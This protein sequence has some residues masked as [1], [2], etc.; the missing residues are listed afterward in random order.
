MAAGPFGSLKSGCP[1]APDRSIF[2]YLLYF[3]GAMQIAEGSASSLPA[4]EDCP[5]RKES[6][7]MALPNVAPVPFSNSCLR[8]QIT[9]LKSFAAMLVLAVCALAAQAQAPSA[10]RVAQSFDPTP[11]VVLKGHHP[12]WAM[13]TNDRG[14]LNGNKVIDNLTMVLARS[15]EQQKAFEQLLSDQQT[16]G[17]PEYHHWLTPVEIGTRFGVSDHDIASI[18]GW[19]ESQGLHVNWVAPSKIFIAFGGTAASLGRAF[20]TEMHAYNVHGDQRVSV[21]SDPM[22]PSALA[23]S[24][25]AVRGL[26]TV[27]ERPQHTVRTEISKGPDITLSGVG[28]YVIG[29]ADFATIYNLPTSLTGSG[30]TIGVVGEAHVDTADI[31]EFQSFLGANFNTPDQVV[32]TA[33]G[34]V[35]PGAAYTSVPACENTNS[36]SSTVNDYIDAQGEATLDVTRA[37]SVAPGANVVLVTAAVNNLTSDGVYTDV[38]YIIATTSSPGPFQ[39]MSIS[40]G[41]CEADGGKSDVDAWNSVYQTAAGEGISV[42]VSSGDSGAAGCDTHGQAPPSTAGPASPNALCSSQYDTCVGGTEFNDASNYSAYWNASNGTGYESAISYIPEGAW[43]EPGDA[44]NGFQVAAT[45]GGFSSIIPTP[46]W[47]TGTGVPSARAG[48]YTPDVSF[49][50]SG[51]DPYF[52]CLAVAGGDC[53]STPNGVPF[54]EFSGT[55]ASAP[56]MAGIA[57][58]L[59]QQMGSGQGNLNPAIYAM[60]AS[61]PAAFHDVTVASSGV[62]SCSVSTP[63]MC[64]NSIAGHTTLTGGTKGYAVQAGYDEA[65]GWGSLDVSTFINGFSSA[66]GK[67]TPT[68]QVTPSSNSITTAQSLNVPV[69]VSGGS[70]N[71]APTGTVTLTSGTYTSSPATLSSGAATILV[72]ANSLSAGHPTLTVAYTPD[73]NS[74][75]TYYTATGTGT[76]TVALANPIAPVIT[77]QSGNLYTIKEETAISVGAAEVGSYPAPSG[78][79]TLTSGIYNSGPTNLFEGNVSF[80]LPAGTLPEGTD[81]LNV[82]YTPDTAGALYYASS[83]GTGSVTIDP[84][85]TPTITVSPASSSINTSQSLPVTVTLGPTNGFQ[86]PVGNVVLSSGSYTSNV[87]SLL[88]G[89]VTITIP[90]EMLPVGTDTVTAAF[91]SANLDYNNTSAT[92]KITVT[93]GPS[94]TLSA[95][96]NSVSIPQ[97]STGTSTIT[98]APVNGFTGTVA[99]TTSTLPSGVTASF[100]AGASNTEVMTLAATGSATTGSGLI[101]VTGTSGSLTEPTSVTLTITPGPSFTLAAAPASVSVAQGSTGTSTVTITPVNGFTGTVAFTASGLPSGVTASF[102]AGTVSDTEVMTLTA[103]ISATTG[104]GPITVTGTS[105]SLTEQASVTLE[106]TNEPSFGPSPGT[107]S[108]SISVAPGATTGNTATISVVGTYGFAGTV[109]MSCAVTTTITNGNDMPTCT[110]SPTSVDISGSAA[111]TS[112]LTAHTTAATSA[113]N[114]MQKL[115]WPTTGGTALALLMFFI[116]PRRRRSWLAMVALAV[117]FAAMGLTA[118]GGGGG[119]GGGGGNSGTT[120]GTYTI[121]VTGSANSGAETNKISTVTLTVN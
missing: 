75:N 92:T 68:V 10:D 84:V 48:R 65:T 116:T 87:T 12:Q 64:N 78:T 19:L 55:S 120:A 63:S 28:N 97:G 38:Q 62:T 17:S 58:L 109:S 93:P 52:A 22:V 25:L 113:E 40:F 46:T 53:V 115:I 59:D 54:I 49:T 31:S 39:V 33:Q 73:S 34:G 66:T 69:T 44:T 90:A 112:T 30:V 111:S 11:T 37:G 41:G 42:F 79:V 51:H 9:D 24:I 67:T 43:N 1:A 29:P 26:Y 118:C 95:S 77:V 5:F 57:A 16:A 121:T 100:A 99:F 110:L 72:P 94:F 47:Q 89:T 101:T 91:T 104:S 7:A 80:V 32:P 106:I 61:A 2:R 98:I 76:V 108:A 86:T 18:S 117:M 74:S 103:T 102:A 13:Q 15:P 60:A 45:G 3:S 107:G 36:C 27:K 81:P 114:R 8:R 21:V 6:I 50:A 35:D 71:P 23:P 119:G 14:A 96:P 85:Q 88:S 56:D 105:G 82:T 70:G 83:S 20:G 4:I